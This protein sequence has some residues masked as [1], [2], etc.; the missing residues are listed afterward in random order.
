MVERFTPRQA[1]AYPFMPMW[2]HMR[3]PLSPLQSLKLKSEAP[4]I[5][6]DQEPTVKLQDPEIVHVAEEDI[7]GMDEMDMAGMLKHYPIVCKDIYKYVKEACDKLEHNGSLMYDE[8]PD[9]ET[10][11][12]LVDKIYDAMVDANQVDKQDLARRIA[13]PRG[14]YGSMYKDM[15]TVILVNEIYG[16]RR[17]RHRRRR[18]RYPCHHGCHNQY[19]Y[20]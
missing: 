17:R 1:G 13:L 3:K 18:R 10:I 12:R 5:V 8:I 11:L 14:Y 2:S 19:P 9:K 15:I 7:D 16:N 6:Q 4:K 20:Y